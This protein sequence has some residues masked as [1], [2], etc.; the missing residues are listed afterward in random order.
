[1]QISRFQFFKI[2]MDFNQLKIDNLRV[3]CIIV[4]REKKLEMDSII[5]WN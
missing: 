3:I 4:L 5:V 1:M 2:I